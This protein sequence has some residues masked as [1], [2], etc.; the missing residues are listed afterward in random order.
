[1]IRGQ[2]ANEFGRKHGI[3]V[4]SEFL[5]CEGGSDVYPPRQLY[6]DSNISEWRGRVSGN[7]AVHLHCLFDVTLDHASP[8]EFGEVL[9][10][11]IY[12]EAAV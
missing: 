3:E 7:L 8:C 9:T 4:L 10:S 11:V 6:K 1:M 12:Q 2:R 5:R